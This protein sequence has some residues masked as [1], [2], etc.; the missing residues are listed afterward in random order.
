M[1]ATPFYA[2]VLGLL[3]VT[4]SVRAIQLRRKFNIGVGDGGSVEMLRAMRV[5]ANFAEYV[6]LTLLMIFMLESS[7]AYGWL[8]HT[9]CVGLIV[10]R[11]SHA[12]GVREVSEDLRYRV[13]GMSLT[14]TALVVSAASLLLMYGRHAIA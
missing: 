8:I 6:P 2:A 7:G 11:L 1:L 3:F 14:F 10:G 13:F 9:L 5:H 4:L 12:Y